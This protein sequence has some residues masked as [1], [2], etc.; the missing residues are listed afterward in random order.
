MGKT[1]FGRQFLSN[2]SNMLLSIRVAWLYVLAFGLMAGMLSSCGS[3]RPFTYMQGKFDTAKLSQIIISDPVIRKGDLLNIIVY[4]DNPQATAIYNQ[5]LITTASSSGAAAANGG[6]AAPAIGVSPAT[7]GYLVDERGN[8]AFQGIGFL[9]I[10]G[11]TRMQL[12]DTLNS[13]LGAFLKNPFYSIRFL[14]YRI[15]MLGEVARPGLINIPGDQVNILEA[16]GLAG[17]LTFYGRRDNVLIIREN[18]GK[19]EFAR[20]DLTKPEIMGSPY[21][22]LQQ[23]DMVIVEQDKK[24]VAANDQVTI[25][26]IS[27]GATLLSTLAI[28]YTIFR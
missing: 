7:S 27:I 12:I 5:P 1:S 17:D 24:K 9:H 18:N 8:I 23:N 3:T 25:R 10:E 16:I 20:L 21:F 11:L 15:T 22:Y 6:S 4:S 14:N 2:M 13:R 19:R 28:L 26:N